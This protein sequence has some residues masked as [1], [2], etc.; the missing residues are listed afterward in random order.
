[1]QCHAG[2]RVMHISNK[3][4]GESYKSTSR[5]NDY[6]GKA[7]VAKLWV[8]AMLPRKGYHVSGFACGEVDS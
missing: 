1:M 6:Y 3:D 4:L 2:T 8:A 7:L 5:S